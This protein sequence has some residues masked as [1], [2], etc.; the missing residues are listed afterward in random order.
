M[1]AEKPYRVTLP[2]GFVL[3]KYGKEQ[4]LNFV[5]ESSIDLSKPW[6]FNFTEQEIKDFYERYWD[7]AVEVIE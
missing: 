7:F 6:D 3:G 4:H 2:N 5:D 1:K